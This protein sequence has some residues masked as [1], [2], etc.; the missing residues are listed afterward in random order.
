MASRIKRVGVVVKKGS[1]DSAKL[2]RELLEYG[3][4]ELELEM[5]LDC[6]ASSEV[7]WSNVFRLGVDPIDAVVVIGGDGTLLRTLHR[8]GD[9]QVPIMTVRMGRRGFLL[10]VPPFE[11]VNRLRDLA[12]GRFSIVEY[13]RLRATIASNGFSMPPALNDVVIQSWGPSKTKVTRLVVYVDEDILYSI[14]GDG[15]IVATPIGSSAYA[16]AAGGP[17]V[18][19]ELESVVV[20]PLAAMQFNAKPVVLSP[21]RKISIRVAS[22]SGPA[23]C[24]VDGQSVEL[25]KPGDMVLIERAPVPA[26]IIRFARVNSY[27][28]LRY[29]AF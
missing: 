17:V 23:A 27:D 6:E 4:R 14:D 19:V 10:D 7:L 1:L 13:M 11:A 12:E 5:M 28:R 26:K 22:G 2:A 8:L 20:V 21:R 3:A 9:R 16:L 18:D 24:V 29:V 25:L 15:V